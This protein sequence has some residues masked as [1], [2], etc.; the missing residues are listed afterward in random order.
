MELIINY[1]MEILEIENISYLIATILLAILG[2]RFI[3]RG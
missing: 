3:K 2:I 1:L